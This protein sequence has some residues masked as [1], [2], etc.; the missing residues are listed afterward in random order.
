MKK[1][2]S[3]RGVG[4]RTQA[5][6]STRSPGLLDRRRPGSAITVAEL[7]PAC[8]NR[9]ASHTQ[10]GG[11]VRFGVGGVDLGRRAALQAG[12]L[13]AAARTIA[14][15]LA[16]AAPTARC[17]RR[18]AARASALWLWRC[19]GHRLRSRLRDIGHGRLGA[20]H[21]PIH[22]ANLKSNA[23]IGSPDLCNAQPEPSGC[24]T[25]CRI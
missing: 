9:D 14:L 15:R 17:Q 16:C 24:T 12:D 7:R 13:A 25:Q 2:E 5:A 1:M 22:A 23:G 4:R 21:R 10:R 6:A 8:G 18:G 20:R 11:D 3:R 19:H